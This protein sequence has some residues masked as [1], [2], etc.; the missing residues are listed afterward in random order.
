MADP[1]ANVWVPP[2]IAPASNASAGLVGASVQGRVALGSR[3]GA[4]VR[5]LGDE[6]DLGHASSRGPRQ[7]QLDGFATSSAPRSR[8]SA[9]SSVPTDASSSNPRRCGAMEP[10]ISSSSPSNSLGETRGPHPLPHS[11]PGLVSRCP[12]HAC[13]LAPAGRPLRTGSGPGGAGAGSRRRAPSSLSRALPGAP[14]EGRPRRAGIAA[15]PRRADRPR[16]R[17][18]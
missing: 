8:R 9:S 15:E 13:P 5:R 18:A 17:A 1:H 11:Q 6:P 14:L 7:A 4:R 16:R 10:L 3:A 12:R 2:T